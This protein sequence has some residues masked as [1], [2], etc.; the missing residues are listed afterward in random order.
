MLMNGKEVNHLVVN[1]ET[2][3]KSY[4]LRKIRFLK[5]FA[6]GQGTIGEGGIYMG[7]GGGGPVEVG[8]EGYVL[9]KYKNGYCVELQREQYGFWVIGKWI[10]F[11]D[12][13]T[14]VCRI[15]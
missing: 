11:I 6:T 14:K 15:S 10:E 13:K 5:S 1:G 12:D 9:F 7:S 2:F 4:Y 3:D 8:D